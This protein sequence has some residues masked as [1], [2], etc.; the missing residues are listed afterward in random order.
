MKDYREAIEAEAA[1][2]RQKAKV[3]KSQ[4]GD[5]NTAYFHIIV[6]V[7]F[8]RNRILSLTVES[9]I[10]LTEED[11]MAREAVGYFVNLMGTRS[12]NCYGEG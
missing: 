5:Q 10:L 3:D 11:D 8:S 2:L 4:H 7:R 12:D 6:K 9:G 1:S